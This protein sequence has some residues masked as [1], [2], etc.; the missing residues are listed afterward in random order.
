MPVVVGS[1]YANEG[2]YIEV[3]AIKP[4]GGEQLR[5]FL[6]HRRVLT[7]DDLG[8]E[9]FIY[10]VTA[11]DRLDTMALEFGGDALK[12]WIIFDVNETIEFPLDLV[13]GSQIKMPT[14]AFFDRF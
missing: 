12:W 6:F 11:A 5:K 8:D 3:T 14:R 13:V 9:F 2:E 10:T 7:P 4:D 1:R